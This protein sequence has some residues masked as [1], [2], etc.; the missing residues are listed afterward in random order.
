[1]YTLRCLC[2]VLVEYCIVTDINQVKPAFLTYHADILSI[3]VGIKTNLDVKAT[4]M[5][6]GCGPKKRNVCYKLDKKR[7]NDI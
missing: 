5:G 3:L 1:M 7:Y 4:V 2:L 6:V